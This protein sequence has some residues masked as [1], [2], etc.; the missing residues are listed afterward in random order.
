MPRRRAAPPPP[1]K[2]RSSITTAASTCSLMPASARPGFGVGQ[3]NASGNGTRKIGIDGRARITDTLSLTGSA[4]TEDYLGSEARRIAGRA[5]LEY[6]GR[7]FSARAGLTIAD[8][9]LAD[10]RTARS[11]ILQL[12][13]T[14]RFFDNRLELD[15]QT[16]LPIGGSDDSIDFPARHRLS[17]RFAV[18]RS[19]ALIGSYEIADGENDRRPHR[20]DRLRARALGRRAHRL[21]R[22][23]AEHRRIWPA[24][25]RRLRPVAVPGALGALVGRFHR[26][27]ATARSAGSIPA[28]CSIRSIRWRAAASSATARRSPR[29]S[30]R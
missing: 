26:S 2:S 20:A 24:Q 16:E 21:D 10:G 5:L 8:D 30:P 15:A 29:I 12:G 23:H 9:R 27:T 25:L 6:R 4:W 18:S 28:A 7:D 3:L 13:A 14:R 11:Q 17:A 22:Q 19:V 1:G